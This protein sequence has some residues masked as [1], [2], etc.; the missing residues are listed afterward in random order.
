MTP[1]I[2]PIRLETQHITYSPFTGLL[3]HPIFDVRS[4]L[5]SHST[6]ASCSGRLAQLNPSGTPYAKRVVITYNYF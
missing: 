5:I 3:D 1:N 2:R 4:R 6:R